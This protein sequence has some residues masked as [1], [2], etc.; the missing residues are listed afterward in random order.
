MN[1][2][3]SSMPLTPSPR[4]DC[5]CHRGPCPGNRIEL[6]LEI[7]KVHITPQGLAVFHADA[8]NGQDVIQLAP[9]NVVIRLVGRDAELV[10][11]AA[12]L[13]RLEDRDLVSISSEGMSAGEARGPAP[14]TAT[15]GPCGA[16]LL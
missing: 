3:A 14:T 16:P 15:G 11:A 6:P 10:E 8:A 1:S 7:G 2:T 13:L 9:G 12:L 5:W 4:R